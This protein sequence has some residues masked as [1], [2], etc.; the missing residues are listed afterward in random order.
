MLLE[1]GI[2]GLV[3][4]S[5]R[6]ANRD[7]DHRRYAELRGM[8]LPMVFVNGAV[9]GLDVPTVS[10]D[11]TAGV[12]S[13]VAYLEG[14]GHRRIGCALGPARYITSQRQAEGFR[15]VR[16]GDSDDPG[17]LLVHSSYTVEG[18][19][20]AAGTLLDAGATAILCGSD[21]MALG[22]IRAA[23]SRGLRVPEDLSV[24]GHDDSLLMSFMDPPLTTLRMDVAGMSR[25][26]VDALIDQMEG[27]GAS[28]AEV[29]FRMELVV[30]GSTAAPVTR[31]HARR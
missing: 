1:R 26:A 22:A 13:A 31:P 17:D 18:G 9:P 27:R 10:A 12:G 2:S 21:L 16:S 5:G 23:V 7:I 30:R 29:L 24:I 14:L 3:L 11:D 20:T 4:V 6:H 15:A 19:Q 28:G 25:H 8:Q